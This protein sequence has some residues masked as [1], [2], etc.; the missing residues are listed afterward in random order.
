MSAKCACI[1]IGVSRYFIGPSNRSHGES[2]YL[3]PR[4]VLPK[5][6]LWR[7]SNSKGDL[8]VKEVLKISTG[9]ELRDWRFSFIDFIL[10]SI[11][12]DDPK[13][14]AA[15]RRKGP[16]FYY[17]MITRTLY[18]ILLCCLS[19]EKAHEALREAHGG[20]FRAHRHRPKLEDW[21]WRLGY[22]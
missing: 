4:L 11:L 12:P 20:M 14:V 19:C 9:P 18:R 22:Y 10:Y 2:T 17:N 13:E 21:L 16:R 3:L 8:Q 1:C 7:N 15:I 5:T 6:R